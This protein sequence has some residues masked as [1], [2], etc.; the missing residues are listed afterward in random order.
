MHEMAAP[1]TQ[2]PLSTLT[3][4]LGLGLLCASYGPDQRE[5]PRV[6]FDPNDLLSDAAFRDSGALGVADLETFLRRSPHGRPSALAGYSGPDGRSV[7]EI[8]VAEA[9]RFGVNPLVLLAKLQV[10]QSLVSRRQA[11]ERALERA[12]G[13]GCPDGGQCRVSS[14]GLHRQIR[15]AAQHLA[16]YFREVTE[17]G[18]TR[19]LWRIGSARSAVGGEVVAPAN[20]AT[21]SLY[22][23]TPFVLVGRGGNWLLHEVLRRYAHYLGYDLSVGVGP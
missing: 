5:S 16:S 8:L 4:L 21:A 19:T 7:A 15:C 10:E 12:L 20:G 11:P 18:A 6:P 13:C 17:R 14:Q 23:Y 9:R 22:T 3:L 1:P 2:Q